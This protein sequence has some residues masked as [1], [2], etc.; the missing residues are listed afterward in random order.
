M[1]NNNLP[2]CPKQKTRLEKSSDGRPGGRKCG[3][4]TDPSSSNHYSSSTVV[5]GREGWRGGDPAQPPTVE[6][7]AFKL[8]QSQFW[9]NLHI[10]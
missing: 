9:I 5:V 7:T 3:K 2:S 6:T 8:K 1:N 4:T 10:L